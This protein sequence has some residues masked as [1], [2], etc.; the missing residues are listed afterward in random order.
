KKE[1]QARNWLEKVIP[2]LIE[3]YM[4]LMRTTEDLR[5]TATLGIRAR[6]ECAL[7]Q[8][9][10][11]LVLHFDKIQVPY[12]AKCELVAVQLV[13][14]GLFPCA[15]FRPSLAVDIRML[16][17]VTQLF[18]RVSPNHTAWCHTLE[19]YL[20]SQGYRIH[21]TN[22]LRRRFANALMWFNSLQNAVVAHVKSVLDGFR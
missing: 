13:R 2:C 4:E 8:Q 10:T 12:C 18:L 7:S 11:V 19:D 16:D 3:P 20:G 17:F 9:V 21:G 15:P 1:L 14:S 6:C 5:R 22:P